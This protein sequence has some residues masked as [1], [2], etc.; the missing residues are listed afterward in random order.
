MPLLLSTVPK[1]EAMDEKQLTVR[2]IISTKKEIVFA[3]RIQSNITETCSKGQ[4]KK[5]L[6]KDLYPWKQLIL[7]VSRCF[8]LLTVL[9]TSLFKLDFVFLHVTFFNFS[10]VLT[11][12]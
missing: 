6:P 2:A 1:N 12:I 7:K 10:F 4:K 8:I 11:I 5:M 3:S 9:L